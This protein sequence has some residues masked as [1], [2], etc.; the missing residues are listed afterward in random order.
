MRPKCINANPENGVWCTFV[1]NS[2]DTFKKQSSQTRDGFY[3]KDW[4]HYILYHAACHVWGPPQEKFLCSWHHVWFSI[5]ENCFIF[6][7]TVNFVSDQF[8][9]L[10]ENVELFHEKCRD[11]F[12]SLKSL[13]I[14]LSLLMFIL[15]YLLVC[16]IS[17]H[18]HVSCIKSFLILRRIQVNKTIHRAVLCLFSTTLTLFLAGLN[19]KWSD[20]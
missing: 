17:L 4:G 14:S 11:I 19:E 9:G 8:P 1:S 20:S 10:P 12:E 13:T 7:D 5:P 16:A 2:V 6:L 3:Y 18:S 15:S